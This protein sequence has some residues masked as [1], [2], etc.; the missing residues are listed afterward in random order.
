MKSLLGPTVSL[1]L[2]PLLF[3]LVQGF[4]LTGNVAVVVGRR[5]HGTTHH[6]DIGRGGRPPS[7]TTTATTIR[8]SSS[9]TTTRLM[10]AEQQPQSQARPLAIMVTAEIQ[11]DRLGEFMDLIET[12]AI[13]SRK[14]PGCL[15]FD[16]L[17][18]D[19]SETTFVFYE[20]Y[21]NTAAVDEHK[22]QPHYQKW[23]DFKASGGT[24]T[25]TSRKLHGEFM[26]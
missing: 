1:S 24:I 7:S 20:V 16:V 8:N 6:E 22:K 15:Q 23:A 11:P 12:N 10:M 26:T 14:E 2:L 18:S 19:D 17:R 5:V 21:Q 9:T 4:A 13:A 25:S 3:G